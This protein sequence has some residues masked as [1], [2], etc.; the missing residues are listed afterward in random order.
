[1]S[2][3]GDMHRSHIDDFFLTCVVDALIGES[4]HAQNDQQSPN[5]AD[6]FHVY[7]SSIRQLFGLERA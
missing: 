7:V 5:P 2:F 6:R 3:C 1:M 4:Q